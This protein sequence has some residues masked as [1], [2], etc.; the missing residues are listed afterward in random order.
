MATKSSKMN[1]DFAALQAKIE[2][3]FKGLNPNDPGSWPAFPKIVVCILVT[4]GVVALAWFAWLQNYDVELKAEIAKEETLK[5][6]YNKK[7]AQAV[8][9]DG[10]KAQRQQVLQFVNQIEKQLPSKAEMDALLGDINKA[11]ADRNLQLELFK[12]GN[13]SVKDYYA[14]LPIE[15]RVVGKYAQIGGFAADIAQ[16]SRI[17]TLNNLSISPGKDGMLTLNTTAKTFRYLDLDE[18]SKQQ[19]AAKGAKK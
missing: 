16:L 3:Q 15:L 12:P 10:L 17:V 9:L 7:L 13:V 18:V 14:E 8:A 11:R 6:D 19:T 1:V 5:A 2:S 4:I